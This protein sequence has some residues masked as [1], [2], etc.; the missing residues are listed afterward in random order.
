MAGSELSRG[1]GPTTPMM[2]QYQRLKADHPDALLM[3]RLGDFYELFDEDARIAAPLLDVQLTTRDGIIPMC[4]VPH[5]A[6]MVYVAKLMRAGMSVALA[7]QMEDPRHAKGLVDRQVVRTFSPGTFVAEDSPVVPRFAVLYRD[8]RGWALAVAELATGVLFVT[9]A[10]GFAEERVVEEWD[11]W[12]PD[13]LLSNWSIE[14]MKGVG[15]RIEGE[16]WF[17]GLKAGVALERDLAERLGT[18]SLSSWGLEGEVRWQKALAVLLRY[19]DFSQKRRIQHWSAVH[20]VEPKGG[21]RLSPH[22]LASLDVVADAGPDLYGVLNRTRTPMGARRLYWWTT[23]PLS[24]EAAIRKRGHR[25]QRWQLASLPA[26]EVIERLGGVGDMGRRIARLSLGLGFP[27]D[28][29]AIRVALGAYQQIRQIASE[30]GDEVLPDNPSLRTLEQALAELAEPAPP[31]WDGGGLFLTGVE[32]ALDRAR[33]LAENQRLALADLEQRERER[34]GIRT[35][36]VGYHRTFGYYLEVTRSQ[37]DK[38]PDDWRK[39]QTMTKSER[40]TSDSLLAMEAE[41]LSAEERALAL[42]QEK[43]SALLDQVTT[44]SS[45]LNRAAE[46]LAEVDVV[47]ALARVATERRWVWPEW[48]ED[49][50]VPSFQGLRHPVLET[51]IDNYVP[52]DFA[53]DPTKRM[54]VI[55][56]PNMGGKSTFMRAVALGVWLA[57]MG[58]ALPADTAR[59]GLADGIYT[60]IGAGDHLFRGQST[61]MAELEDVALILRRATRHSLVLL[62]ELGRGTSTYDGLA[63]AT[64]V[65]EYLAESEGPFTLFATHYHELTEL[66]ERRQ[67]VQNWTVEVVLHANRDLVFSHRVIPGC[68]DRSYG[69]DV[70]RLAGLP[71]T[72]LERAQRALTRWEAANPK[73]PTVEQLSLM[74]PNP[75]ASEMLR[76]LNRL[77]L[78][79]LS[80]RQAWEWLWEWK[81]QANPDTRS[82]DGHPAGPPPRGTGA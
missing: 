15:R 11:Y 19:L 64:A 29:I 73:A 9:G 28:L 57:H 55:T 3:F 58:M 60:R 49:G 53:P 14:G 24:D 39:R 71:R 16:Q 52:T 41:I 1:I 69:I 22:A 8:G 36:K 2:E 62:D 72:V 61:F 66:A 12:Q 44:L 63:I 74:A 10:E 76:A 4:G 35:L 31:R 27:R 47:T 80:P 43:I 42:E 20:V 38:V 30:L 59:V 33:Q 25:I 32:P 7:E 45:E 77:D 65:V 82:G 5:H 40:Y 68:S 26:A 75:V 23:R 51:V 34:S 70:A 67:T 46:Y 48:G 50:V 37:V 6:L 81:V 13:E 78:D 17:R 18:A 56:G 54:M 21:L 79:D